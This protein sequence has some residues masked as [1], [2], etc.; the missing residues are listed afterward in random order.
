MEG[1]LLTSWW[2]QIG[3]HVV[4]SVVDEGY[5]DSQFWNTVKGRF[6]PNFDMYLWDWDGYV[7]PGADLQTFTTAQIGNWNEPCWSSPEFDRLY[8]Q[9]EVTLDPT[10]RQQII[11]QMQKL[12]YDAAGMIVLTYPD[13]LEAYNV[14]KWTG[15]TRN[16]AG[17]GG[18]F[19]TQYNR[20][21]YLNLRPLASKG[22]GKS[23][24]WI[25]GGVAI[26]LVA[27]AGGVWYWL[28]RRGRPIREAE[29]VQN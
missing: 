9:Q 14:A 26:C 10:K 18:A 3:V 2:H 22:G 8:R 27:L 4:F 15:W 11:W 20:A 24:V 28:R 29:E 6:T 12:L 5:I 23:R 13:H 7:D 25:S 21:T 16:E 17:H 19:Y 1:K